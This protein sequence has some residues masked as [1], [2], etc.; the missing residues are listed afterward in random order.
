V[1]GDANLRAPVC[2]A[3]F[4]GIARFAGDMGFAAAPE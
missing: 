4:G 1:R 2:D 3:A